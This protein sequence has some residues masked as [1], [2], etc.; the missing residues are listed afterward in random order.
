[1]ALE[2]NNPLPGVQSAFV[3]KVCEPPPQ[4]ALRRPTLYLETTVPS[5]LTGR[6][7]RDLTMARHQQITRQWWELH[8]ERF[9]IYVSRNVLSEAN[10]GDIEAAQRRLAVLEHFPL[11]EEDDQANALAAR[12]MKECK[13][14]H[15]AAAD[16]E[17]IAIAA[18]HDMEYLLTW[19]CAH[20]ANAVLLRRMQAICNAAGFSCPVVCTPTELMKGD[21][22]ERPDC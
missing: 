19:N 12:L 14:P 21:S 2:L 17:H 11:L 8:R 13:L 22:R 7:S 5:Y 9:D 16:A 1:M 15:R 18:F 20:I 3:W 10:A 4:Y 6:L